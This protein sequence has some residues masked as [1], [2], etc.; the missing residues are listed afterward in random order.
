MRL[1][2]LALPFLLMACS[3]MDGGI[4]CSYRSGKITC[5][6]DGTARDLLAHGAEDEKPTWPSM[7]S[8]R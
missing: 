7:L 8:L 2:I 5:G 1:F 4:T 3:S 6:S